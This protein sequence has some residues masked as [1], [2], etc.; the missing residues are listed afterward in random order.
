MVLTQ[1]RCISSSSESARM[2]VIP[3]TPFIGVWI[4]MAHDGQEFAFG[5]FSRLSRVR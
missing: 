5:P 4:F 2:L 3:M 1:L